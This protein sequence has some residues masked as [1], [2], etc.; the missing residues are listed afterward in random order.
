VITIRRTEGELQLM[1]DRSLIT[2]SKAPSVLRTGTL[3]YLMRI[4]HSIPDSAT[5]SRFDE[6]ELAGQSVF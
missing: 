4:G 1:R 6:T 3:P 2:T 5:A